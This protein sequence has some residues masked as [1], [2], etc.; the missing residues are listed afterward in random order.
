MICSGGVRVR[1]T[2]KNQLI[3]FISQP[4]KTVTDEICKEVRARHCPTL[5]GKDYTISPV[6]IKNNPV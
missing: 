4:L 3:V 1:E 6:K 5:A 2:A